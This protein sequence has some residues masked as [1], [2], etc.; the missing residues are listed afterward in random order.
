M[1][2]TAGWYTPKLDQTLH[3]WQPKKKKWNNQFGK[4]KD[5]LHPTPDHNKQLAKVMWTALEENHKRLITREQILAD[6][7]IQE[8]A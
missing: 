3:N 4:L 1:N 8:Q 2:L 7:G 6:I 5:G